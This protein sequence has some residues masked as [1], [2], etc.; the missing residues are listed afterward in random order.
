MVSTS[1]LLLRT[2]ETKS[3]MYVRQHLLGILLV[4]DLVAVVFVPT[5]KASLAVRAALAFFAGAFRILISLTLYACLKMVRSDTLGDDRLM[6]M[7][8]SRLT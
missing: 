8:S 3:D 6:N 2:K 1:P 7:T 5:L 4:E